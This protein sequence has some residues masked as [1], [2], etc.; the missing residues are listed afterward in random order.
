[1]TLNRSTACVMHL[2]RALEVGL[3]AYGIL[4]QQQLSNQPSWGDVL[5]KTRTEI[6]NRNDRRQPQN[7]KSSEQKDFCEGVQIFLEI[8]K[9]KWRNPSMHADKKYTQDEAEEIFNAI[10]IFMQTLAKH[11]NE[12]GKFRKGKKQ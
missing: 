8:V 3:K 10:K 4:L 2:Q 11:L 7:W 1:M 12:K 5:N 6:N 9:N